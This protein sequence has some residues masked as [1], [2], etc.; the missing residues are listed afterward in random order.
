ME[1]QKRFNSDNKIKALKALTKRCQ[2]GKQGWTIQTN[3]RLQ[4]QWIGDIEII[5]SFHFI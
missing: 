1:S 3:Q 5:R 2:R 4:T